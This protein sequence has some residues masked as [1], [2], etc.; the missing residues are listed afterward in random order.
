MAE[1][2]NERIKETESVETL[3]KTEP[4]TAIEEKM[5]QEAAAFKE[6]LHLLHIEV[7]KIKLEMATLATLYHSVDIVESLSLSGTQK[8]SEEKLVKEAE[9]LIN[10]QKRGFTSQQKTSERVAEEAALVIKMKQYLQHFEDEIKTL[11]GERDRLNSEKRSLE[12]E[13][14]G[15]TLDSAVVKLVTAV[16]RF[17][18]KKKLNGLIAQSQEVQS[19]LN[20]KKDLKR[21]LSYAKTDAANSLDGDLRDIALKRLDSLA[22]LYQSTLDA[23]QEEIRF[24]NERVVR[25]YVY[26][27]LPIDPVDFEKAKKQVDLALPD[28]Y[29]KDAAT[30]SGYVVESKLGTLNVSNDFRQ[31]VDFRDAVNKLRHSRPHREIV[32]DLYMHDCEMQ[33]EKMFE[34]LEQAHVDVDNIKSNYPRYNP[35][36]SFSRKFGEHIF[37]NSKIETEKNDLDLWAA[38]DEDPL[39]KKTLGTSF[40]SLY[41]EKERLAL[42]PESGVATYGQFTKLEY[43]PSSKA[44]TLLFLGLLSPDTS[45]DGRRAAGITLSSITYSPKWQATIAD[46]MAKYPE[47]EGILTDLKESNGSIDSEEGMQKIKAFWEGSSFASNVYVELSAAG[48]TEKDLLKKSLATMTI[49]SLIKE[50]VEKGIFTGEQIEE[51][52][53]ALGKASLVP[54]SSYAFVLQ[55]GTEFEQEFRKYVISSLTEGIQK[56]QS[57]EVFIS[58]VLLPLSREINKSDPN[59]QHVLESLARHPILGLYKDYSSLIGSSKGY[60][61]TTQLEIIR[62]DLIHFASLDLAR[63]YAKNI[64]EYP[65]YQTKEGLDYL[66]SFGDAYQGR[67]PD[68]MDGVLK[69]IHQ[70][71]LTKEQALLLPTDAPDL[72]FSTSDSSNGASVWLT[73]SEEFLA[74][75]E[76]IGLA[77][78]C[79]KNYGVNIASLVFASRLLGQGFSVDTFVNLP[80]KAPALIDTN[81]D[82]IKRPFEYA[83]NH[84]TLFLD[85]PEGLEF[86]NRVTGLYGIQAEKILEGYYACVQYG[87]FGENGYDIVT[88]FLQSFRVVAPDIIR[89]Y[90]QAKKNNQEELY[91]AELNSLAEKMSGSDKIVDEER[92]KPYFNDLIRH[93]YPQNSSNFGSYEAMKQCND[94]SADLASYKIK[95]KY[96]IDLLASGEITLKKGQELDQKAI[97][98]MTDGIHAISRM[99]EAVDFEPEK[100]KELVRSQIEAFL[101]ARYSSL[102]TKE[103]KLFVILADA[104]YGKGEESIDKEK[105][106]KLVMAYEFSENEDVRDYI[107]GTSDRVANASNKD[108]ALLC[109]LNEFYNDRVKEV[110]RRVVEKAYENE[111]VRSSMEGRFSALSAER[112]DSKKKENINKLQI[113]KLGLSE[114]FLSQIKRTLEQRSG[115]KYTAAQIRRLIS[116]YEKLAGGLQAKSSASKEKGTKAVYGQLKAQRDKTMAAIR[117]LTGREIDA[118]ELHLGEVNFAELM[119]EEKGIQSG[120]YNEDQFASYTIENMIRLFGEE[121][122]TVSKELGKFQSSSGSSRKVLNAFI[123]KTKESAHARMTGGV[124]VAADNPEKGTKKENIWDM[125][126]YLQM[127]FQDPESLICQGLVLLHAEEVDGEKILCASLNPSSTYLYTVDESALFSGIMKSLET[128]A[129]ENGFGKIAVSSNKA[130]RTNRTGGQFEKTLDS[131]ILSLKEAISFD[132]PRAFSHRPT[133]NLTAMDVVWKKTA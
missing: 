103:D 83:M 25:D 100:M 97:S 99:F 17:N 47:I 18:K 71:G 42:N 80:L 121:Q 1:G 116:L 129:G 19:V 5:P 6:K 11:E 123:T 55:P 118:R 101:P 58:T 36:S 66:V 12:K 7:Q 104:L 131:R 70:G 41:K 65:E 16:S 44:F 51:V 57:S 30:P 2:L 82:G 50:S 64:F 14:D 39:F 119:E 73:Y 96:E 33:M 49:E 120:V 21:L 81:E 86:T 98:T 95:K 61:P 107:R 52:A 91:F 24:L 84:R 110:Y 72:L 74:S 128:F 130:I 32:M 54:R 45:Y 69:K 8:A 113:D 78:K 94:R 125:E 112:N 111:E 132:P 127:V 68:A 115:K 60:D 4:E 27:T 93:V 63:N 85:S 124:C 10:W 38:I 26:A 22:Q 126:N 43:F 133:Y 62:G 15:N 48:S 114:S 28:F 9:E 77:R 53:T 20:S 31:A 67:F 117:E 109:E 79:K 90:I 105:V 87:L 34:P 56:S 29:E 92:E 35:P 75:T 88:E 108:Y 59:N 46:M 89:E 76:K 23:S 122:E 40:E 13:I 37:R 106:K 102:D 3:E